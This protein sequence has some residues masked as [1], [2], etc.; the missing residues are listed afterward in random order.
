MSEQYVLIHEQPLRDYAQAM[1]E[2]VGIVRPKAEFIA[3]SLVEANLRAVD[4]HG[5]QLLNF[6]IEH[7]HMGCMD[8]QTEGSI[9]SEFGGSMTYD[10]ENGVGQIISRVCCDHVI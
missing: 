2:G 10:A 4:S 8:L 3:Q 5:V 6:Y 1:L 7:M 9:V